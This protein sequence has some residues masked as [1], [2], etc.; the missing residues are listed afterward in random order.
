MSM[1]PR[2][3]QLSALA[4]GIAGV[5]AISQANASGF[6]IRENSV[7]ALGRANSGTAVAQHDASVVS[8]NPAA[9]VNLDRTTFQVDATV[10]DV[11]G[12]FNGTGTSAFGTPLNG[13]D[14]GDAG[15]PQ[16]VPAMAVV[17][18]LS[19]AFERMTVGASIN[20]PYGLVTEYDR[21]WVGRYN[22]VKSDVKTVDL[23]LS[24]AVAITDRFSVG[25]GAIYQYADVTLTNAIDFG[26][27]LAA[28]RVPGFAPQS[29]DGFAEISGDDTGIGWNLGF[30]W[31]PT[32]AL[33]IGYSHRSEI[34][35]DLEGKADFTVPGNAAAVFAA[36][37]NTDYRDQPVVAPLTTP[38]TDTLSLQYDFSDQFRMTADVQKTDWHSLQTVQI[39]RANGAL[40]SGEAFNWDDTYGYALG[41]EYDISPAFTLRAG[42]AY[43]ETPTNDAARS[44]RLPDDN[45]QL[46]SVGM[47]W[48]ASEH[49][50]VDAAY[51]YIKI[52]DPKIDVVSSS[53]SRLTGNYDASANLLGVSAQYRF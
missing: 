33:W 46:Y 19:G 21:D 28:R 30:Q 5:L 34:D 29:A 53:S 49:L 50:S 11:N 6:Q 48:N 27:A 22:A 7:K 16:V 4:F 35:H 31:R 15:D 10:I 47:T 39:F 26:T 3:I 32:D 51:M 40:L 2:V 44:P 12:D 43:D 23:N 25:F 52:D 8:N 38:S 45:R 37:G 20:A 13:G 24:A 9:M 41:G 18:P 17:I 36:I 14:G 42:L 1:S